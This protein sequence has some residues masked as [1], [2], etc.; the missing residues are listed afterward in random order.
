MTSPWFPPSS[1][2][3]DPSD[4]P[5]GP[6]AGST[7]PAGGPSRVAHTPAW[8]RDPLARVGLA[9]EV[10]DCRL[11]GVQLA[12]VTIFD[13]DVLLT[14]AGGTGWWL[15]EFGVPDELD[16]APGIAV[17]FSLPGMPAWT[18]E[19]LAVRLTR[20]ADLGQPL[21]WRNLPDRSLACFDDTIRTVIY[22]SEP[23]PS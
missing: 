9:D 4:R 11:Q 2:P 23:R 14:T 12:V 16:Y 21:R 5:S 6:Y 17:A 7:L 3:S 22:P 13:R 15:D 19:E 20:W 8:R 10:L 1:S 18:F